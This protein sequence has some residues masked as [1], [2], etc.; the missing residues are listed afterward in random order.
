[1]RRI[2]ENHGEEDGISTWHIWNICNM[3][4]ICWFFLTCP[5]C[6]PPSI[7]YLVG[8][9]EILFPCLREKP[10]PL[11]SWTYNYG[12]RW[13][14]MDSI[15]EQSLSGAPNSHFYIQIY[16]TDVENTWN[17]LKSIG[18]GYGKLYPSNP[19][20]F[21]HY[22][23]Q[24]KLPFQMKPKD[25]ILCQLKVATSDHEEKVANPPFRPW[26]FPVPMIFLFDFLT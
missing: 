20:D 22:F 18:Y 10:I 14:V 2:G 17:K 13:H 16:T 19:K 3:Y 9:C 25:F 1:M 6:P 12:A 24:L 26:M 4:Y 23:C 21:I 11:V 5:I 15:S 8:K 7:D